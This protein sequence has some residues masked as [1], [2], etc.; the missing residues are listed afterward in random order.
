MDIFPIYT[1]ACT[2]FYLDGKGLQEGGKVKGCDGIFYVVFLVSWLFCCDFHNYNTFMEIKI[3]YKICPFQLANSAILSIF[4]DLYNH[5]CVLLF[6][7]FHPHFKYIHISMRTQVLVSSF[8]QSM[9]D[10]EDFLY[11]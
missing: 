2:N 1:Q 7:Y 8:P 9:T 5:P 4:M 6:Q 11:I 3:H 10:T